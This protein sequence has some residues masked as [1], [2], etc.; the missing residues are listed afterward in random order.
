MRNGRKRVRLPF[1]LLFQTID[2]IGRLENYI[3][4]AETEDARQNEELFGFVEKSEKLDI[5]IQDRMDPVHCGVYHTISAKWQGNGKENGRG[6]MNAWIYRRGIT[7]ELSNGR[8]IFIE[9]TR[10]Y[11]NAK[12]VSGSERGRE[13]RNVA[14][15]GRR[16]CQR[17]CLFQNAI[18]FDSPATRTSSSM[19]PFNTPLFSVKGYAD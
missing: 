19:M 16:H 13:A 1:R 3:E 14:H 10:R 4:T 9:S 17:S 11:S 5:Y 18:H 8:E 2:T 15:G 12:S 6:G 7:G